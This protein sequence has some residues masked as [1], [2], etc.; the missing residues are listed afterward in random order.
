MPE[1]P[2]PTQVGGTH[3]LKDCQPWDLIK[4]MPSSGDVFAD[5]ARATGIGYLFRI[6]GSQADQITDLHKCIHTLQEAA[7]RLE[8]LHP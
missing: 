4:A 1:A 5:Y 2:T 7:N 6:K 3:Y 8:A